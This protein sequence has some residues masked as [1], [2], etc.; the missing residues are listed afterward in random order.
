MQVTRSAA[1]MQVLRFHCRYEGVKVMLVDP[2]I[3]IMQVT[4]S[5]AIIQLEVSVALIQMTVSTANM[6]VTIFIA[7]MQMGSL[8]CNYTGGILHMTVFIVIMQVII[9]VIAM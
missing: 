5:V 2:S 9:S 1:I 4:V 6:W 7:I 3:A 8:C